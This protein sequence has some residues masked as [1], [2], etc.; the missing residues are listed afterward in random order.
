MSGKQSKKTRQLYRRE[1]R[2]EAKEL[3]KDQIGEFLG[4]RI[5]RVKPKYLPTWIWL[6]MAKMVL[7][8]DFF[9]KTYRMSTRVRSRSL[10]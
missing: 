4:G 10:T 3:A 6:K 8:E 5:V 7:S 9:E 1:F 2:A